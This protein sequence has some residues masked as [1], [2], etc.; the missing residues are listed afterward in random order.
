MKKARVVAVCTVG[1]VLALLLG[2]SSVEQ[3]HAAV[4][5]IASIEQPIVGESQGVVLDLAGATT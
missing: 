4:R 1:L 2:G 5:D 3:I